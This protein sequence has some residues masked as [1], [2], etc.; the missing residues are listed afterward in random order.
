MKRALIHFCTAV[1]LLLLM[2][3]ISDAQVPDSSIIQK[4]K[5]AK[6]IRPANTD[7]LQLVEKET[8]EDKVLS[9]KAWFRPKKVWKG[10]NNFF[11]DGYPDPGKAA[12]LS[13]FP[14]GGQLYN[15]KL[16]YIKIPV[17]YGGLTWLVI[18]AQDNTDF[19]NLYQNAYLAEIAGEEH[20]FSA[21]N[22]PAS[23]LQQY[24]DIYDKRRQ[25]TYIAIG[26]VYA[27]SIVEA[28]VTAHLLSFDV[29]EDLSFRFKPSFQSFGQGRNVSSIGVQ[30]DF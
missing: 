8:P 13:L 25:Q 14:G 2:P 28:Y 11:E 6:F 3:L 17:I 4:E 16:A 29:D 12:L 18:L 1:F 10:V 5:K 24:R 21:R 20:E 15:K 26:A 22:I 19:Y 30:F 27:L 9:K 23:T 7:S